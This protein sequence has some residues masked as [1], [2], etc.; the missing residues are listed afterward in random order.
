VTHQRDAE[1][2]LAR[3]REV[4]RQLSALAEDAPETEVLRAEAAGLRDE[5]QRIVTRAIEP[6]SAPVVS[7][8]AEPA[9]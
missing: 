7:Q 2:V 4:E 9:R 1:I 8:T 3:W 5:Y 6:A